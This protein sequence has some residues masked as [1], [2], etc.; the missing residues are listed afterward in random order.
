MKYVLFSL[1]H[2]QDHWGLRVN[3]LPK[4]TH[5]GRAELWF[6]SSWSRVY[7]LTHCAVCPKTGGTCWALQTEGDLHWQCM[8]DNT[9]RGIWV[10]MSVYGVPKTTLGFDD[11]LQGLRKLRKSVMLMVIIY[12]SEGI[13]ITISKGKR[14]IGKCPGKARRE[15]L[16]VL[17][18]GLPGPC[19]IL[20]A[21]TYNNMY[22]V[23]PPG[24]LSWASVSRDFTGGQSCKHGTP[25]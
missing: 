12:Y 8:G 15:L 25:I 13:W 3:T 1:F 19:F 7:T 9:I 18:C 4:I 20:P 11:S 17:S 22:E 2:R 6:W 10:K 5:L 21:M 16:L 24:M 14:C 23:L